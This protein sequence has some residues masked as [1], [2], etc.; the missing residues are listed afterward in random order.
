MLHL[1][2][3]AYLGVI[4]WLR[5]RNRRPQVA[6]I[7]G[8]G[9]H[10]A[11]MLRMLGASGKGLT[12]YIY[13]ISEND[14]LTLS[15]TD[16]KWERIIVPRPRKVGQSAL[17]CVMNLPR[18]LFHIIIALIRNWPSRI[19]CNGPGLCFIITAVAKF[20]WF[21]LIGSLPKVYVV[22]IETVARVYTLSL[23]GKL[24][25]FVADRF[26]VQWPELLP[27]CPRHTEYHLLV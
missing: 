12:D 26:I 24:M 14:T 13:W 20:L 27:R 17:S 2:A 15:K 18:C 5:L 1:L 7:L 4:L 23:T 21:I 19:I 8:S 22:Y 11:E 10:T 6:V 25:R 9:G 16:K 3:A